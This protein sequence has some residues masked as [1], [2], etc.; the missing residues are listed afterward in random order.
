MPLRRCPAPSAGPR[1][2]RFTAPRL[3]PHDRGRYHLQPEVIAEQHRLNPEGE[4]R[5]MAACRRG[6]RR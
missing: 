3:D 1:G 6:G 5:G 2:G 4:P